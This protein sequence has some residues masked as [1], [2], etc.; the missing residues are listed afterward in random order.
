MRVPAP[1]AGIVVSAVEVDRGVFRHVIGNACLHPEHAGNVEFVSEAHV[2][3]PVIVSRLG[4][5]H[6]ATFETE[7]ERPVAESLAARQVAVE[8]RYLLAI[9]DSLEAILEFA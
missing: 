4:V 8:N 5:D 2:A 1:E 7:I 6:G 9:G 3:Q